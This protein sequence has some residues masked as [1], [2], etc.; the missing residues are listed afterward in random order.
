[1]SAI[2]RI[3]AKMKLMASKYGINLDLVLGEREHWI[4]LVLYALSNFSI[5]LVIQ[6]TQ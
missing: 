5:Y 1:M 2:R 4:K 3:V 6:A